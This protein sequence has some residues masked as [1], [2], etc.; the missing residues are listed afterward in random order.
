[1]KNF[2]HLTKEKLMHY[3]YAYVD[4]RDNKVFYIGVG[5]GDRI[6][7]HYLRRKVDVCEKSRIINEI[8][9]AD[10]MPK[11]LILRDGLKTQSEALLVESV[12]IDICQSQFFDT[13]SFSRLTN[14]VMGHHTNSHGIRTAKTIEA[15]YSPESN[16]INEEDFTDGGVLL[17]TLRQSFERGADLYNATRMA[18][19]VNEKRIKNVK[20]VMPLYNNIIRDVF[21]PEIWER[22]KSQPSKHYFEGKRSINKKIRDKY[23]GRLWKK[24]GMQ[25]NPIQYVGT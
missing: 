1:M 3:V 8:I 22:V 15:Q 5:R 11:M 14:M 2:S 13:T 12:W 23:I 16:T 6:F 18:W 9:D 21:E 19:R 4:P 17:V 10:L 24:Y 7:S 25:M 20:Y